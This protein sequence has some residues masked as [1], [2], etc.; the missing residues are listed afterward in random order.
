MLNVPSVGEDVVVAVLQSVDSWMN[1]LC[2][3]V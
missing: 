2:D 3:G 1:H